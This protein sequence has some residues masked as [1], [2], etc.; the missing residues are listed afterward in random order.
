MNFYVLVCL[1]IALSSIVELWSNF[2]NCFL[3]E[4][5]ETILYFGGPIVTIKLGY[6]REDLIVIEEILK[7]VQLNYV[8]SPIFPSIVSIRDTAELTYLDEWLLFQLV[9]ELMT[10]NV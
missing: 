8:C 2:E 4:R 6:E 10:N 7:F 5:V 9:Q 3:F 1:L